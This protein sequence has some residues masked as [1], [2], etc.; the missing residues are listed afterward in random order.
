MIKVPCGNCMAGVHNVCM[1]YDGKR[2]VPGMEQDQT[3]CGCTN[4]FHASEETVCLVCL[5]P[6]SEHALVSDVF[7][8]LPRPESL[9]YFTVSHITQKKKVKA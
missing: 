3:K 5:K 9:T 7:V 4:A 6:K 1:G 8:C 2:F